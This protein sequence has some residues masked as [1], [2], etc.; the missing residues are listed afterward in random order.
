MQLILDWPVMAVS[1]SSWLNKRCQDLWNFVVV[2]VRA[3]FLKVMPVFFR[4]PWC[5]YWKYVI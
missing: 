5:L 2:M 3:S 1:A 4:K